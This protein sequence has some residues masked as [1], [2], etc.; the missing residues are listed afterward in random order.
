VAADDDGTG[1]GGIHE[2]NE[3]NNLID[4]GVRLP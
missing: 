1:A 2:L 4:S 3:A